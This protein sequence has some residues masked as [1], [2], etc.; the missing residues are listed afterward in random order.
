MVTVW[1]IAGK[2]PDV[3]SSMRPSG[4][5]GPVPAGPALGADERRHVSG[6]SR[7]LPSAPATATRTGC[8]Y[9]DAR[10]GGIRILD[11]DWS[12][13]QQINFYDPAHEYFATATLT[14]RR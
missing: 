10:G 12:I 13:R 4:R 8:C 11:S 14:S 1:P 9:A 3:L 7:P 2:I 5:R 6:I